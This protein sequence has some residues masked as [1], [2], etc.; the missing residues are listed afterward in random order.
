VCI[1]VINLVHI[2]CILNR[3]GDRVIPW[4]TPHIIDVV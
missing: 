2:I 4:G 1:Q 3:V